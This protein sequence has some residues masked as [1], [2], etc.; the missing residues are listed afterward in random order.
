ML[1]IEHSIAVLR[2]PVSKVDVDTPTEVPHD[3]AV[4]MPH[5]DIVE[6]LTDSALGKFD[7]IVSFKRFV[8]C[9]FAARPGGP[10]GKSVCPIR[11]KNGIECN[12]EPVAEYAFEDPISSVLLQQPVAMMDVELLPAD[13]AFQRI[14][15]DF[16]A[17]FGSKI[18]VHP[19]VMVPV[20]VEDL[21]S[22]ITQLGKFAQEPNPTLRHDRSVFKP[23]VEQIA[24]DEQSFPVGSN[25]V[26]ELD[27][28]SLALLIFFPAA[29][30]EMGIGKEV[31]PLR[32][33]GLI[34]WQR[35][36]LVSA[37]RGGTTWFGELG[38]WTS[39]RSSHN[40][41][42]SIKICEAIQDGVEI[43]SAVCLWVSQRQIY[44]ERASFAKPALNGD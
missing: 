22:T 9:V 3:W 29:E 7:H 30:A 41:S 17:E 25:T 11:V 40:T 19:E 43:S 18:V 21:D 44:G 1:S 14:V 8:R 2:D 37:H 23:V 13:R 32:G 31:R 5:D 6:A 10:T 36:L 15:M 24:D 16:D 42:K 35:L 33:L 4:M 27:N 20:Y 34:V 38:S 12:A 26:E 39:H 28:S